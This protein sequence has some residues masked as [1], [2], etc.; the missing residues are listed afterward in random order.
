MRAARHFWLPTH[1]PL[2]DDLASA[3]Q[4]RAVLRA[5]MDDDAV[6]LAHLLRR[7]AP[8]DF[9][10]SPAR[11]LTPLHVAAAL[12]SDHAARLL[13]AHGAEVDALDALGRTPLRVA[14]GSV[15]P[16]PDL[17]REQVVSTLLTLGAQANAVDAEGAQ[18]LHVA[19]R[20]GRFRV[21]DT[22]LSHGAFVDALTPEAQT[23]VRVVAA[24]AAAAVASLTLASR[25]CT[26]PPRSASCPSRAC[27]C[28]R[29]PTPMLATHWSA[30]HSWP[31][32]SAGTRVWWPC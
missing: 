29:A 10:D 32:C 5:V 28:A 4:R 7:G 11:C 14:A 30:R 23:A 6:E 27:S 17:V 24:A 31:R 26:S 18:P 20:L 13:L 2:R 1:A 19:A 8:A 16:V 25:S 3:P 15:V 22:L 21:V 9:A 12:G